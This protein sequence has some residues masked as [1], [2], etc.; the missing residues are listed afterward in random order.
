VRFLKAPLLRGAQSFPSRVLSMEISE[1]TGPI[2][3]LNRFPGLRPPNEVS[4]LVEVNNPSSFAM[5]PLGS[6][7][8][9]VQTRSG[10]AVAQIGSNSSQMLSLPLGRSV[11]RLTGLFTV[12]RSDLPAISAL[13]SEHLSGRAIE[14]IAVITSVSIPLYNKTF[15]GMRLAS[16]LPGEKR[17]LLDH[18]RVVVDSGRLAAW[19]N[20]LGPHLLVLDAFL[21]IANPLA[22]S[23][24]IM[25]I[26]A[27]IFYSPERNKPAEKVGTMRVV[28]DA[29]DP[30]YNL[31]G[32]AYSPILVGPRQVFITPQPFPCVVSGSLPTINAMLG[33]LH[34]RG[35]ITVTAFSNLSVGTGSI[36]PTIAYEQANVTVLQW[37]A[38]P[39]P[40][41]PPTTPMSIKTLS[42]FKNFGW[43]QSPTTMT[44]MR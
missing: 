8:M 18:V 9:Q 25:R 31:L 3:E 7:N 35:A 16:T 14:L 6:L 22:A 20:P 43:Y 29:S 4:I 21:E 40:P 38:P 11:V 17:A 5:L 12:K 41:A 37:H 36:F 24:A 33:S 23:F 19:A 39:S 28:L 1:A 42:M 32:P 34:E 10:A 44:H 13:L 2:S 15:S 27:E 26:D 30:A